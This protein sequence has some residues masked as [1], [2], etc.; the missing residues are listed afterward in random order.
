MKIFYFIV[1]LLTFYT[2][3]AN[4]G[5]EYSSQKDIISGK[6]I[7]I[8]S[9]ESIDGDGVITFREDKSILYLLSKKRIFSINL[10]PAA[11]HVNKMYNGFYFVTYVVD[12][13]DS[14]Q[15]R[16][17]YDNDIT[18]GIIYKDKTGKQNSV[19]IKDVNN[20]RTIYGKI[21]DSKSFLIEINCDKEDVVVYEFNVEGL[22]K[23]YFK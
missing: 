9:L 5:W 22:S 7:Q 10:L 23:E 16:I 18:T 19:M 12:L 1:L 3:V 21:C 20:F 4:A 14:K 6:E 11:P 15:T 8:A 17:K 2:Q 13:N